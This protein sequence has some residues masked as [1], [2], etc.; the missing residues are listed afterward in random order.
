M[1]ELHKAEIMP[2]HDDRVN[3]DKLFS[4][5]VAGVSDSARE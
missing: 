3:D 4:G 2:F 1:P 5:I